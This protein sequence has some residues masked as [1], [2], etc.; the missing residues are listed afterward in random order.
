[1]VAALEVRTGRHLEITSLGIAAVLQWSGA[2][3]TAIDMQLQEHDVDDVFDVS[4]FVIIILDAVHLLNHIPGRQGLSGSISILETLRS[5]R[6]RM[7]L[8][9]FAQAPSRTWVALSISYQLLH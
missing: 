7:F 2:R 6:S 5:L 9:R 1:M 3:F 4:G 8:A